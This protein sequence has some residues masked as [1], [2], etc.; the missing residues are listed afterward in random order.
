MLFR[1]LTDGTPEQ[2]VREVEKVAENYRRYSA[3]AAEAAK[4]YDYR[5]VNGEIFRHLSGYIRP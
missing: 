3:C 2:I 1:S 5:R 4:N